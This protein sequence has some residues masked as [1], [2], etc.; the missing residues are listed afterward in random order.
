MKK[1][2]NEKKNEIVIKQKNIKYIL[3]VFGGK[4]EKITSLIGP[5]ILEKLDKYLNL[6]I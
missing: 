3:E 5:T 4:A 2:K 6:V 1:N